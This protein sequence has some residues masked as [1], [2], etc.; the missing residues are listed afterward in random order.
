M[1]HHVKVNVLDVALIK[2][3]KIAPNASNQQVQ[4]VEYSNSDNGREVPMTDSN[5]LKLM[6][7]IF[8]GSG[9]D[10]L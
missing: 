9:N 2:F 7:I 1:D 4:V 8:L 5:R 10:P 6:Q 3:R